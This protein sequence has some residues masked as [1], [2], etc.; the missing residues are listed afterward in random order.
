MK[1]RRSV[2]LVF[3]VL[4]A[5][6][7]SCQHLPESLGLTKKPA[8]M[9]PP[10]QTAPAETAMLRPAAAPRPAPADLSGERAHIAS[11]EAGNAKLKSEL[12]IAL[13]ENAKLKKDLADVM[14]DNALLK[15]LA[16]RKQR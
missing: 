13:R 15:D 14:D 9:E 1:S 4:P 11:L 16:A 5:I 7:A 10:I 3:C 2:L 8:P 6:L 12:A